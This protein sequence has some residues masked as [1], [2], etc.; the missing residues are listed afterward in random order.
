MLASNNFDRGIFLVISRVKSVVRLGLLA[1]TSILIGFFYFVYYLLL[2]VP[3][4]GI[5][6]LV[7]IPNP[8]Y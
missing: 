2:I 1:Y 4:T 3:L 5:G 7:F 6:L 8:D